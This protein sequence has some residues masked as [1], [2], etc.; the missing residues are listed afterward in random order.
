MIQDADDESS[1]E[2]SSTTSSEHEEESV[3]WD[4]ELQAAIYEP[5]KNKKRVRQKKSVKAPVIPGRRGRP[6]KTR[7]DDNA[8]TVTPSTVN[9]RCLT[10]TQSVSKVE[11]E[12]APLDDTLNTGQYFVGEEFIHDEE[13]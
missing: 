2:A 13:S 4:A 11:Q 3:N 1:D 9:R 5:V 8:K 12:E 7:L 10:V 6:M